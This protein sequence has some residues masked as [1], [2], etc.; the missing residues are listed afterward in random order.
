MKSRHSIFSIVLLTMLFACSKKDEQAVDE[1]VHEPSSSPPAEEKEY[2]AMVEISEIVPGL[3]MKTLKAGEGSAAVPG[4]LVSVHYTGW[5]FD[6]EAEDGRGE[7]FD[8]SVDRG[9]RFQFP[10]GGGRVIKGWDLGVEGMLVGEVRELKIAPELGYGERGAG[11]VIPP[12][13]ILIFEVEYFGTA[14]N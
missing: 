11:G 2:L 9:E 8:S 14:G 5:L 13:A 10:L 1:Q 12:G 7:K 4:D 6:P 3:D